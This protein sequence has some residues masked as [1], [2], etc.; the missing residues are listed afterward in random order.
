MSSLSA[1][2]RSN[3]FAPPPLP[4]FRFPLSRN[5]SGRTNRSG[6]SSS[7]GASSRRDRDRRAGSISTSGSGGSADV[8]AGTVGGG[9]VELRRER[10]RSDPFELEIGSAL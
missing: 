5:P 9:T 6:G 8:R 4:M 2:T 7:S 10:N 1:G 3:A